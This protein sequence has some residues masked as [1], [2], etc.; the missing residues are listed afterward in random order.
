MFAH[1]V[2]DAEGIADMVGV[3]VGGVG[4]DIKTKNLYRMGG[5]LTNGLSLLAGAGEVKG[6]IDSAEAV[7][8]L[9]DLRKVD[10]IISKST[11]SSSSLVT[12]LKVTDKDAFRALRKSGTWKK[13]IQVPKSNSVLNIRGRIAW[14]KTPYSGFKLDGKSMPIQREFVPAIG[15]L[16]DRYGPNGGRFVSPL[17]GS[18]KYTYEQRSMP[19]VEDFSQYHQYEV[20]GDFSKIKEY[21]DSCPDKTIR[22]NI[23]YSVNTYAAGDWNKLTS[24][25]GEIAPGFDSTGGGVQIQFPLSVKQL[26]QV[27]L[28]KQIK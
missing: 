22:E 6:A 1:P 23:Y 25:I 9:N 27:G 10:T 15:S 4:R 11:A 26:E 16:V 14:T 5:D 20:T 7:A 19:Y 8:K 18:V 13:E 21:V 17:S 12:Y 2:K 3:A 28:L 24:Q